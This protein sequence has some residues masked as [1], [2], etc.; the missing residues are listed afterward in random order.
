MA[1]DPKMCDQLLEHLAEAI[2]SELPQEL[3]AHLDSCDAC[4]DLVHDAMATAE[5]VRDAG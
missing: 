2:D 1:N 5:R 4:R 3:E